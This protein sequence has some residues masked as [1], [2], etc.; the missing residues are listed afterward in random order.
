MATNNCNIYL[1][2]IRLNELLTKPEYEII[3]NVIFARRNPHTYPTIRSC[4]Q[5]LAIGTQIKIKQNSEGEDQDVLIL[6]KIDK[7]FV[8]LQRFKSTILSVY[9]KGKDPE[10]DK[11]TKDRRRNFLLVGSSNIR[12]LSNPESK[13][14]QTQLDQFLSKYVPRQVVKILN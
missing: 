5:Q 14:L 11:L 9:E 13:Y 12:L 7:N 1:I 8:E 4:L 10:Y 6:W 2:H 3:Y